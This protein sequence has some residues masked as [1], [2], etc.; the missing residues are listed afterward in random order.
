MGPGRAR[1]R[2]RLLAYAT[3]LLVAGGPSAASAAPALN[4]RS[5]LSAHAATV[6]P[7]LRAPVP[8]AQSEQSQLEQTTGLSLSEVNATNACGPADPGAA[9]CLGRVLR[10][11]SDGSLVRPHVRATRAYGS[12][13]VRQGA[14]PL[15][16]AA[17]SLPS[18]TT[19]AW[20]QQAYDLTFLS[21]TRGS[22]N[23]VGIV[24]AYDDPTAEAD[25]AVYRSRFG[26][27][28][29]TSQNGCF[30]K[31][32]QNGGT[33]PMP[34]RNSGWEQEITL[35][36]D[37]VSALCPNCK[38]LLVE[39]NSASTLDLNAA[40]A[41]AVSMGA[42]EVSNSWG[43][44]WGAVFPDAYSGFGVPAIFASGD[45]GYTGTSVDAYPASLPGVIAAGGTTVSA[46]SGGVAGRG[47]AEGAWALNNGWGA[48]SGCNLHFA[49]PSYQADTGCTGRSYADISADANP[50][51]GLAI[52]DS[53]SGGWLQMGGTSLAS[54]LVAAYYAITGTSTAT[55]GWAYA[56]SSLLNDPVGGSA[57]SCAAAI[58]YICVAGTGYDG[59]TGAG[60]I[61][62]AVTS[63]APG[64][65]GPTFTTSS[66]HPNTYVQ[67]TGVA[68]ATVVAGIYPN[69]LATKYWVEYGTSTSYGQQTAPVD[70]GAGTTPLTVSPALT[71]LGAGTTYHFRI[72]AQNSAGTMYGYDDSLVTLGA[73]APV[74]TSP[75]TVTG[76]PRFG[77]ALSAGP[78]TWSP[79]ASGYT[80][81]WQRSTDHGATWTS[82]GGA[83][84]VT[85]TITFADEN[86][87]IRAAVT[88]ANGSGQ[89]TAWSA[90]IGPVLPDPPV[91]TG[92]PALAGTPQRT[93]V[94][95]TS[96][97]T[98]SG[99]GLAYSYQWQRSPDRGASWQNITGA[100]ATTYALTR[101]DEGDIVRAVVTATNADGAVNQPTT[102]TATIVAPYPPASTAPPTVSGTVQRTYILTGTPGTWTGP[103]NTYSY[104][105][106]RDAGDGFEDIPG[107]T[108]TA[109][110]LTASD[111]G[112]PVRVVVTATNP[113]AT[114]AEASDPTAVVLSALPVNTSPPRIT[115][116][117]QRDSSLGGDPGTWTGLS[118]VF[119]YQWQSSPD[120]TT[121]TDIPSATSLT[122]SV[123][124]ADE[125]MRL[126][127]RVTVAN[128]D[129][130]RTAVSG[131]SAVVSAAPP[132]STTA[133]A[134]SGSAVRGST[135]TA[136]V[137][138]WSGV[139]NSYTYQWQRDNGLGFVSIQGATGATYPVA[140][141]DEA[142]RLR[143]LV[144]ASNPDGV[145][146]APSASTTAVVASP[147][148]AVGAPAL[149]G[150]AQRGSTLTATL[151]TWTGTGNSFTY[152]WQR[153]PDGVTWTPI[154]DA[155][156]TTY[157]LGV[158][159]EGTRLRVLV[160]AVNPDGSA[161]ATSA[162]SAAVPSAPPLSTSAPVVSGVTQRAGVLTAT[163]GTWSGI[164]NSLDYQWQ[165]SADG[166]V[167]TAIA[168]AVA[169][170]YIIG[171]ADENARLRV[172]VTA[173][174]PDG[175]AAAPSA[176]TGVVLAAPPV[177]TSSPTL[178]GTLARGAVLTAST[179]TWAGIGNA[180]A[181]QWQ[182]SANGSAWTAIAGATD[183][184][185]T[186]AVAD[187]RS[188]LRV[189]V[190]ATNDDAA[191]SAAS[192]ATATVPANPPVSLSSPVIGGLVQ[193]GQTL[194]ASTG[195]WSGQQNGYAYQ[196]QRSPDGVTWT[197][198]ADATGTTYL[199]GVADEG[200]RLRVLVTA[201]NP[202]GSASA[203]SS[204][205]ATVPSAPPA[206]TGAPSVTGTARRGAMLTASAGTWAGIG[207][208]Y[209]YHWQR[210]ADGTTW[211]AISGAA[212]ASYVVGVTDEN[213]R[214]RVLVTASDDDGSVT[215][216]S[217]GTA[218]VQA[219]PPRNL[220]A[221]ALSG[222][223]ARASTL[224]ATQGTWSGSG[225]AYAYA[226]QRDAGGGFA[227]IA[228]ATAPTYT[229][230][231]A[232]ENARLRVL[233]TATNPDATVAAASAVT[234][235]VPGAPPVNLT[236]PTLNG[237]PAV[238]AGVLNTS[239]G[240]WSGIGNTYRYAWQRSI[241]GVTWTVIAGATD[242]SYT[243]GVADE[244]ARVRALVTAVNEDAS[245]SAPTA[246]TSAV[247]SAPPVNIG[248]PTLAGVAQRTQTLA[249]GLASGTP[250]VW[251]GVGNTY[252]YQWQRSV[253]GGSWSTIAGAAGTSY[254]ATAADEGARLRVLVTASNPD[255]LVSVG[256]VASSA[257]ATAPPV[258]TGIPAITGTAR[259]GSTL[260][261]SAGQ[262]SPADAT[263]SYTWQRSAG[264]GAW[265]TIS[266]ATDVRYTLAQPD[267][268]QLV[269]VR[270]T[271]T[272]VDGSATATS[273]PSSTVIA[274]PQSI[275]TPDAPSGTLLDT[276]GLTADP[277]G[278][279][280]PGATIS[281]SWARCPAGA[282]TADNSCTTVGTGPGYTLTA[283]DVGHPIAVSVTAAST[284]GTSSAVWSALSA[285]VAGRP[286]MN[287]SP[288][289]I[290]GVPQVPN[291]L[292]AN[293]GSWS[294]PT[295]STAYTWYR[296][297]LDGT[298]NCVPV[299][300]NVTQY[301]LS[302]ADQDHTLVL[303]VDATSPGR[304]ASARSA[305]VTVRD[306]PVAVNTGAPTITGGTARGNRLTGAA[307]TWT[308]SPTYAYQWQRCAADGSACADIPGA[309]DTTYT[310]TAADEGHAIGLTV[311]ATNGGGSTDA[312]ARAT[313]AVTPVLPSTAAK[314][315]PRGASVQQ[316]VPLTIDL[317]SWSSPDTPAIAVGWQRCAADGT[318]CVS[319]PG[320]TGVQYVPTSADVGHALR[321]A[322]SA[323]NVDGTTT[324]MSDATSVVLPAPPRWRTLPL[325]AAPSARVG[326]Q[327]TVTPGVWSGPFVS[328]RV[329]ALMVCTNT[330]AAVGTA[331]LG[332]HAI[333]NSALGAILRVRETASNSGGSTVVWSARYVGPVISAAVA[334]GVLASGQVAVRNASGEPL[335]TA[336]FAMPQAQ[337]VQRNVLAHV[338]A[339]PAR[340]LVVRRA[341][342]VSGTLRAWACPV[343]SAPNGAPLPC[344]KAVTF[345]GA[346]ASLRLPAGSRGKVRIV[347]SRQRVRV[348]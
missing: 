191:A 319:L 10:V 304:T 9:Q 271:A 124:T 340:S 81:Q 103:D 142:F 113:D 107:A 272:N 221:P 306:Q 284:G 173:S 148:L 94:L 78:G 54:P 140:V 299:A 289:S 70:I 209:A 20:L 327:V 162:A 256:S 55:P 163:P 35:D 129:G 32:N 14:A 178:S 194:T 329:T 239:V 45:S 316:S 240:T 90:S 122:Y 291:R 33:S 278:W 339:A 270:V 265:V 224:T 348:R 308:N 313:A 131:P 42:N 232:D 195:G 74:N 312:H 208:T 166:V 206:S 275:R 120:G 190:T 235:A 236:A 330:C 108:G 64:I 52:Y 133:P 318:A 79:S 281:Y 184:S 249:V 58:T 11:R 261:A 30:T 141:A 202:D 66:G 286:L 216:A 347:V 97:G 322:V 268:G 189:L 305:A 222:T 263:V 331:G 187:E 109:Y 254:S 344:S 288:P 48:T 245:V 44:N 246:P 43:L 242:P 167:W 146:S 98:W 47:F 321:A 87:L 335:A 150:A 3:C 24:D 89:M 159:D 139:G 125:G 154:A 153:S 274:P 137:G 210:S 165:R 326:D 279:D 247:Q 334:S 174:N 345:R 21:Q 169:T 8:S 84:S 105:W 53:G 255:G 200:A 296:C 104:Q 149:T 341:R 282:T 164:G 196:W 301:T 346:R 234:T 323:T 39:S 273:A 203:T 303:A 31:V 59:P 262:W 56:H 188:R 280:T 88:A 342:R 168:G 1:R 218:A 343:S 314:P 22:G 72:V 201:T 295:T 186:I 219:D 217:A 37:A 171:V 277:G 207:N 136:G 336:A 130:S 309:G 158:A 315:Q 99:T 12:A 172:L 16:V 19:P 283:S 193:R 36:L 198:V 293:P 156:G 320:T 23:T 176:A 63:G 199:L 143:V 119:A 231:V 183:A 118:N 213:A 177:N 287:T 267:A 197:P 175:T 223:V 2:S 147:P 65:G 227:D 253:S 269:R 233:V 116:I 161:A 13:R 82:I 179:G 252:S 27:P 115:G 114:I 180:Y 211:N 68:T 266:G 237:G 215:A 41:R 117:A 144:T 73:G 86:T 60:S 76:T 185:Y 102:A 259:L 230:G 40:F 7:G 212:D 17:Q 138:M 298:S 220:G 311:T 77:Q 71:G 204:A 28:A 128:P 110:T 292:N 260:M 290:S 257:V 92:A 123:R 126:R 15:G 238:R 226:W 170:S 145:A 244:N 294:V 192:P 93:A 50:A 228:G 297:D 29:C 155:T 34:A 307:G 324:A 4:L 5:P 152:Q 328:S 337:Q 67:T 38:I 46:A 6:A 225:N 157:L 214:L 250:G 106:Q 229:I 132:V 80:Y 251:S 112:G 205:T 181:Y 182:R 75:P 51:T 69:S 134:V 111:E 310:A 127:L 85:Y 264:P 248:L 258:S 160:T 135:L 26:L 241:D 83:T 25:L 300:G 18:A 49:K 100:T 91:N 101:A 121:W 243:L 325:I 317:I 276:Y 151:G 95:S 332:S 333:D 338:A 62:G 61:S 96:Q 302:T 57:G 285:P